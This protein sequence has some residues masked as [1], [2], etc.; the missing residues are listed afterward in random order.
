MAK[1]NPKI[2]KYTE[3]QLKYRLDEISYL[4]EAV[5][6]GKNMQSAIIAKNLKDLNMPYLDISKAT[7]LSIEEIQKL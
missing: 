7:G 2:G 1:V 6:K 4:Q 5:L 3:G